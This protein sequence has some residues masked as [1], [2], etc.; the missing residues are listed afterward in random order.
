MTNKY[1]V[2]YTFPMNELY[3]LIRKLT[4]SLPSISYRKLYGREAIYY[5]EFPLLVID[6][7]QVAIHV[8]KME[9]LPTLK[10][11]VSAWDLE[12]RP[13]KDWYTLPTSYNKKKN[14]LLPAIEAA[15]SV[16]E[17]PKPKKKTNKVV[18]KKEKKEEQIVEKG[19]SKSENK[20]P[21]T[22]VK[23]SMV[24]KFFAIFKR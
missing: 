7:E 22:P 20:R 24:E 13:M 5:K 16:L 8:E 1:H 21:A 17:K 9:L 4:S 2:P 14:K 6:G 10:Q 12:G 18:T 11:A 15:I 3:Q 19:P 23:R